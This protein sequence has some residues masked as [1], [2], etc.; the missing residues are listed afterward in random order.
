MR[1]F[2]HMVGAIANHLRGVDLVKMV[3]QAGLITARATGGQIAVVGPFA[4]Q[5][6]AIA[7]KEI[8]RR[9]RRGQE[10]VII[11]I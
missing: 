11:E 5:H 6:G 3:Q 10:D 4:A 2:E 7:G 1:A 8:R 9:N